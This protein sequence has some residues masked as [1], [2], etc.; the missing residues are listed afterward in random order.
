[1]RI[2]PNLS[3][4]GHP[5]IFVIGDTATLSVDGK[6]LAGVA[7]VAMQQGRYVGKLIHQRVTGKPEPA[8]FHYHDK[9]TMAVVGKGYAV[10][11]GRKLHIKGSVAW[12][13]SMGVHIS[14]LAQPGLR[15]SVF[16]Q[17]VWTFLT[18]QRGSRLIVEHHGFV[19]QTAA[20]EIHTPVETASKRAV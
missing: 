3:V 15:L 4:P 11:Q 13:A 16:L 20:V 6:P 8:P 5:D 9:G 10:L 2:Q 7:Q 17:W 18:R 19:P 1:M 12:F 14:F